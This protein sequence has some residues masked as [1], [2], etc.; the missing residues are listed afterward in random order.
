VRGAVSA[1]RRFPRPGEDK[2]MVNY[3]SAILFVVLLVPGA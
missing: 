2:H 1:W 3:V